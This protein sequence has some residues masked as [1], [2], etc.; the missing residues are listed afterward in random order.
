MTKPLCPFLDEFGHPCNRQMYALHDDLHPSD[1]IKIT[2]FQCFSLNDKHKV[3]L[4][5]LIPGWDDF[6]DKTSPQKPIPPT[7]K[8]ISEEEKYKIL[9]L[10]NKKKT[11]KEIAY[12]TGFSEPAIWRIRAIT[13]IA[14]VSVGIRGMR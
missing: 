6:R 2:V 11:Y 8:R 12:E 3:K 10:I 14:A 4:K 7:A 5:E 13:T 9:T 1:G